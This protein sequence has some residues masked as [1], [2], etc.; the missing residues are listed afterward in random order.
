MISVDVFT[1]QLAGVRARFASAL[2]GKI[3]DS[4]AALET[5]SNGGDRIEV[6]VTTHR[7]LHEICGIAPTLGFTATGKAARLAETAMREAARSRRALTP[8]EIAAVKSE[9]EGL[10]SAA[11]ADMQAD[12]ASAKA[13]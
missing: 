4:F 2:D 8:A 1:E 10:R 5:I 6:V 3:A 7:R 9:L 13:Q 12:T 11:A